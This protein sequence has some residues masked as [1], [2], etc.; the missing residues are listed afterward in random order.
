MRSLDRMAAGG[1]VGLFVLACS[2]GT[3]NP[4]PEPDVEPTTTTPKTEAPAAEADEPDAGDPAPEAPEPA[5]EELPEPAD[6]PQEVRRCDV[7]A[8]VIDPDPAGLNVR[9]DP[10]RKG[11]KLGVL[12][13][14]T[15][16]RVRD[17]QKGWVR[18]TEAWDP[19]RDDD[20]ELPEGWVAASLLGTDLKTPEEYGPE[21]K[22]TLK[23][24]LSPM[25][26]SVEI[27]LDPPPELTVR[28]C[29]GPLLEVDLSW[30]DGTFETGWLPPESHCPSSVTTCP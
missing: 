26:P 17:N 14:G 21:M 7:R 29:S 5:E 4:D 24:D 1:I 30:P 8:F 9:A 10:H 27:S 13:A 22:P 6:D 12:M 18:V 25:A 16:V 2:G 23:Q 15:Q 19:E 20:E 11:E 3:A 28:G